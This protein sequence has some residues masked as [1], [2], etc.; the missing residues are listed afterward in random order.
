MRCKTKCRT[1]QIQNSKPVLI[2]VYL[3]VGCKRVQPVFSLRLS[4][5]LPSQS[6]S[7]FTILLISKSLSG[8]QASHRWHNQLPRSDAP[9][10]HH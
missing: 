9:C 7:T 3:E 4:F 1:H 8:T 2:P 5:V 6:S 10:D